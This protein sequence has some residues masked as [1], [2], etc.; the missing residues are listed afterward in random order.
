MNPRADLPFSGGATK[1]FALFQMNE[2]HLRWYSPWLSREFEMLSFETL[3]S[4]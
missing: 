1:M 3:R 4:E 2:R